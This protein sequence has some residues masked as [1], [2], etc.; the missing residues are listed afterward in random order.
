MGGSR[1]G[2]GV[3]TPPPLKNHKNLGFLSNTDPDPLKNHKATKPTFNI[4]LSSTRQRNA[5]QMAFRWR[6]DDGPLKVVFGSTLP[7]ITKKTKNVKVG[8]PLT[9]LP[10]SAHG[11]VNN[12]SHFQVE[13]QILT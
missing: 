13:K 4:G 2:Q 5:I 6:D 3:R 8:P 9:K 1:G 12:F 7:S 11:T 10:G